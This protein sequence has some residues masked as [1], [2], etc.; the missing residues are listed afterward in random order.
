[1]AQLYFLMQARLFVW[2]HLLAAGIFA[3][4]GFL[5]PVQLFKHSRR[6]EKTKMKWDTTLMFKMLHVTAHSW[7]NLPGEN[8][9]S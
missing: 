8:K 1:M 9:S 3:V 7:V 6:C 2:E 5:R 4:L